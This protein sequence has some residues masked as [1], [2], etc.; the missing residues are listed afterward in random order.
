MQQRYYDPSLQIFYSRDPVTALSDPVRHFNP[1]RYANSNPYTFTDPD[2]RMPA[3]TPNCTLEEADAYTSGQAK[4]VVGALAGS[5][6]VG[7]TAAVAVG[8]GTV[9]TTTAAAGRL[10]TA[11]ESQYTAV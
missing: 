4:L 9:A 5:A 8:T 10:A 7:A 2:G 11:A 6:V 1:Y 3:C